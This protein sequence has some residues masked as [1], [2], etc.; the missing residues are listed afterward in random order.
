MLETTGMVGALVHFIDD[1][2]EVAGKLLDFDGEMGWLETDRPIGGV[3][4]WYR[5]V[6]ADWDRAGCK[7]VGTWHFETEPDASE[8][9]LT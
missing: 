1:T 3:S 8:V 6:I 9:E 5:Y 2:G 4:P 7:A